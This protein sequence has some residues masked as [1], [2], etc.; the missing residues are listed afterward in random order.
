MTSRILYRVFPHSSSA[1][2]NAPGHAL[3]VPATQGAG[4]LDNPEHYLVLYASDHPAG[5]VAEAFGNHTRWGD[6]MFVT[7]HGYRRSLAVL[8][9]SIDVLDLDDGRTLAARHLRPSK[10]VTRRYS[11]TQAWALRLFR[12]RRWGGV[13]WWSRHESTWGSFGIWDR[14]SM[15]VVDVLRLDGQHPAVEEAR[16]L[17]AREWI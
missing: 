6:R 17:L 15:R 2:K 3:H 11:T 5:A 13:R 12:M 14:T 4:R 16:D 7:G 9:T 8:E 1:R 10:V